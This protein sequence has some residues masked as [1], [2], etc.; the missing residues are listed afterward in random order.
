[1]CSKCYCMSNDFTNSLIIFLKRLLHEILTFVHG[2]TDPCSGIHTAFDM[3]IYTV[4]P[5]T[6]IVLLLY[7][8]EL[9]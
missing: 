6:E 8:L 3:K 5:L 4:L 2:L 1:M 9:I 7:P